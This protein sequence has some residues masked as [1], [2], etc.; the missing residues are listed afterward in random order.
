MEKSNKS[1]NFAQ[2]I[3][4]ETVL[5]PYISIYDACFL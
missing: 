5:F 3:I 4:Y 2:N 1:I